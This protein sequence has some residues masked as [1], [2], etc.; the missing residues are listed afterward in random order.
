MQDRC[1]GFAQHTFAVSSVSGGSMGASLFS[2]LAGKNAVNG[3]WQPCRSMAGPGAFEAKTRTFLGND[4]L[5]PI[6]GAALFPD[7]VQ[8]LLPV[9]VGPFDRAR[10]LDGAMETAWD[11]IEGADKNPYRGFFLDHWSSAGVA[12]ALVLNTFELESGNRMVISPFF[13]SYS[14]SDGE[15]WTVSSWFYDQPVYEEGSRIS[16]LDDE[17]WDDPPPVKFDIKLSTAVGLSARFPWVLPAATFRYGDQDVRLVDGGYFEN[18]GAETAY[19]IVKMLNDAKSAAPGKNDDPNL[20]KYEV[21][22]IHHKTTCWHSY[23][24]CM[25]VQQLNSPTYAAFG[26]PPNFRLRLDRGCSSDA[27][28]MSGSPEPI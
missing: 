12:P 11:G 1:P 28:V 14:A 6:M 17:W 24:F 19:D 15:E 13:M 21:Y 8:Q 16:K 5:A 7:F 10:G 27:S 20:Q 4:F 2:N 22:F 9:P 18:S 25:T 26:E 23:P 3:E